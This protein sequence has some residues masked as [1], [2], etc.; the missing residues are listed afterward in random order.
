VHGRAADAG[1]CCRG[2]TWVR[3]PKTGAARSRRR[4]IERAD[5]GFAPR[6]RTPLIVVDGGEPRDRTRSADAIAHARARDRAG[7]RAGDRAHPLAARTPHPHEFDLRRGDAAGKRELF[8]AGMRPGD[9]PRQRSDVACAGGIV[10]HR[11]AQPVAARVLGR[12]RPARGGAR[13]SAPACIGA[14]GEE[15]P[16]SGHAVSWRADADAT[17]DAGGAASVKAASSTSPTARRNLVA[18]LAR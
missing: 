17:E 8:G 18:K 6:Q 14:I 1:D 3:F 9:G 2:A 12:A 10:A 15:P 11:P 16:R 4:R 13:P 5:G 7:D